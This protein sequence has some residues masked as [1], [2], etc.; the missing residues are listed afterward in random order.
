MKTVK[1][2]CVECGKEYEED[3]NPNRPPNRPPDT[4]SFKCRIAYFDRV[5]RP[6]A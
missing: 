5:G 3:I 4:C 1:K 6:R 2:V